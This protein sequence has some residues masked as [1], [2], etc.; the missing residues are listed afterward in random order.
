MKPDTFDF[1]SFPTFP[2]TTIPA[3]LSSQA[4]SLS[5]KSSWRWNKTRMKY[6]ISKSKLSVWFIQLSIYFYHTVRF[7]TNLS[8]QY[9][10]IY[11]YIYTYI[12]SSCHDTSTDIP[13]PLSPLLPIAH[14]IWQVLRATFRIPT[15][16]LYVGSKLVALLLL[17][18][19][20]GS[21]G[22]Y[23]LWARPCFSSSVLHVWFVWL[24]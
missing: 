22:E 3:P 10:Y 11:I 2:D 14:R 1:K 23:H 4:S 20:R 8:F 21:I 16:L 12:S 19:V 17:S 24:G 9:I 13:D 18:H 7:T 5:W 15:E 6:Y